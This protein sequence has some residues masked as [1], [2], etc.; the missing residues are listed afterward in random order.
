VDSVVRQPYHYLGNGVK[1]NPNSLLS[2][3]SGF[4][5]QI[6][7]QDGGKLLKYKLFL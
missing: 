2:H 3:G 5:P 1:E 7:D 4:H 6:E